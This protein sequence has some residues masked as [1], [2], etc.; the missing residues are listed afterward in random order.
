MN[1]HA[2]WQ[3]KGISFSA[4]FFGGLLTGYKA[5]DPIVA[6]SLSLL[7]VLLMDYFFPIDFV[8]QR[9][10]NRAEKGLKLQPVSTQRNHFHVTGMMHLPL[11]VGTFP[12]L[13]LHSAPVSEAADMVF[14]GNLL[15][16]ART[17]GPRQNDAGLTGLCQDY[18]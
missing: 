3:G 5:E 9:N 14:I 7:N 10:T 13:R 15:A 8:L 11:P 2:Y 12:F 1:N 17:S 6:G 4:A 18:F 16:P